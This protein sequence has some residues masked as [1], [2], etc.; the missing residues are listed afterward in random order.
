MTFENKY[1]LLLNLPPQEDNSKILCNKDRPYK[2]EFREHL[3]CLKMVKEDDRDVQTEVLR[4][5]WL[6]NL[7]L[8]KLKY[9]S[10]LK[11]RQEQKKPTTD[12]DIQ[13]KLKIDQMEF[14]F[15]RELNPEKCQNLTNFS[16]SQ[17]VK[18]RTLCG[19]KTEKFFQQMYNNYWPISA[20]MKNCDNQKYYRT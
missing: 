13:D 18:I 20:V 19:L 9:Q 7:V 6:Q 17:Y 12:K 3:V 4:K 2:Q 1:M 5:Q 11:D 14:Q 10:K 15:L 16:R 8:Q